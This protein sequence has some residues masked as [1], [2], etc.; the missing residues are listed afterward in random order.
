MHAFH[1][2]R[3]CCCPA[4]IANLACLHQHLGITLQCLMRFTVE[5]AIPQLSAS[6]YKLKSPSTPLQYP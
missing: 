5:G 3:R 6:K 2:V 4:I 1:D